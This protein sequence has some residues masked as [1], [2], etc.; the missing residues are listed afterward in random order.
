MWNSLIAAVTIIIAV[1]VAILGVVLPPENLHFI[2]FVS[3]FFE[4]MIPILAVG[5][6][7]KYLFSC[8]HKS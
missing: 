3:R 1:I 6:L 4:I 2:I 8:H 5:C 7:I